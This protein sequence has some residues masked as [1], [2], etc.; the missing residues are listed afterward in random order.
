MRRRM[1]RSSVA[2]GQ[3]YEGSGGGSTRGF[4]T[5]VLHEGSTRGFYPRV[6]HQGSTRGFY[7]KVRHE[8]SARRFGTKLRH[9]G[10]ARRFGRSAAES[11]R[12]IGRARTDAG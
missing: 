8:G 6:L 10:S 1:T 11:R 3:L 2:I 5:R 7:P 4:Y 12:S 9:E